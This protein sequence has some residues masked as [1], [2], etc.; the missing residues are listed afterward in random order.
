MPSGGSPN[1]GNGGGSGS[2]DPSQP[3]VLLFQQLEAAT[4]ASIDDPQ[5][6]LD[7]LVQ[8]VLELPPEER[9][10]RAVELVEE[11]LETEFGSIDIFEAKVPLAPA[12]A[13]ELLQ[14]FLDEWGNETAENALR[15]ERDNK[16]GLLVLLAAIDV[17]QDAA[18][19]VK[20]AKESEE[21]EQEVY[22]VEMADLNER[23]LYRLGSVIFS[24]YARIYREVQADQRGETPDFGALATDVLY[25]EQTI[26]RVLDP[27]VE[28]P[29]I[30]SIR[31]RDRIHRAMNRGALRAYNELDISTAR[32]A[33]LAELTQNEFV[34]LLERSGMRPNYGP[35]SVKDLYSGPDLMDE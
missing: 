5:A 8:D 32:G 19:S 26:V 13:F 16:R 28:Y 10:E 24:L 15:E 18:E 34:E 23:D 6:L 4:S 35:D 1:I 30:E 14:R 20:A 17:L 27:E 3:L 31:K 25:G 21:S 22:P 7:D 33:E 29:A 9:F 2:V 12:I 11:R